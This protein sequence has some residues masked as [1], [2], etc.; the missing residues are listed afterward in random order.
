MIETRLKQIFDFLTK[1]Y[2]Y[3]T[4]EEI[5][6]ALQLSNKTIQKEI[7]ILNSHIK[8]S[9]AFIESNPGYGY[10]FKITDEDKFKKFLKDDW[11][12][13]AY[14]VQD[15]VDKEAR[16]ESIIRLFLFS[17]SYIKQQEIADTFYISLSQT[18]KD[19]AQIKVILS[20]YNLSLES[21]PYYGMKIKGDEKNIRQAI[22]N[23]V[24]IDPSIYE[25][26]ELFNQIQEIIADIDY[27]PSFYMP[28]V[29]FKNLVI[30]IYIS[31]LRIKDNNI[32]EHPKEL[33][34]KIVSYEEFEMANLI[35]DSLNEK[36]EME[37]PYQELV[38][39]A[40]HL[41]AK[42]TI[43]KHEKLSTEV[44]ALAQEM[45]D[46]I[47][48]VTK[49][50]FRSNIDLYFSL[51]AHL[52][53]LIERIKYGLDM[54]NPILDDIKENQVAF[55]IATIASN[56]INEKYDIKLSEDEIGYI[57]LHVMTA[58]G[59]NN[60]LKKDI[61]VIC[62]SG[63]SSAQIMKSQ[64]KAKFA[65]QI[66][67]LE[68]TDI[69][70]IEEYQ[71]DDYD[72]IV[73]SINLDVQTSTPIVYVDILFKQKDIKNIES[74][75]K[76]GGLEEI[77][78]IFRNS[79]L[80]RDVDI[81]DM[82]DAFDML[83]SKASEITGLDKRLIINQYKQREALGSTALVNN[84]A[85]PHI[86]QQVESESFSIILIPNKT[87]NWDKNKV[88]LLYSLFVGKEIGDMSLYYD[89]LGDFLINDIAIDR[90]SKVKTTEEF[91]D[92]FVRGGN[93]YE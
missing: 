87:I 58:M 78:K 27:G 43:T 14:F 79:I 90:A 80:I 89:K 86:L 7:S 26:N 71:L 46:V 11:Y 19:I 5:G 6:K 38:Y 2:E 64:L 82:D 23:E 84:V 4:S 81:K 61:L 68:L 31:I 45:I 49:Y 28:Y 16:I 88:G 25:N 10:L 39:I 12:K 59:N 52:G 34:K 51:C 42:N 65:N 8:D 72:F 77:N 22:K 69:S 76:G 20:K 33:Q 1:D 70:K 17:N 30:H 47:Y 50:D 36:L 18:Q 92:I 73:S 74:A 24:G 93:K 67:K 35:V 54:K 83:A 41:V 85:L 9:G 75:M 15:S 60:D 62:G 91:M 48:E 56:V 29:N 37:I 13:H 21:K 53:P 3:H 57:A 66:N 32:I 44:S 40:M 55:F 63:N